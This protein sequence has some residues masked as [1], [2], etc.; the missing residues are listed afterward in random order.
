MI[1][2][3]VPLHP[4]PCFRVLHLCSVHLQLLLNSCTSTD[5]C[6]EG[7]CVVSDSRANSACTTELAVLETVFRTVGLVLG[8]GPLRLL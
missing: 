5:Q 7:M 1:I 3:P 8:T 4:H 2:V 6:D